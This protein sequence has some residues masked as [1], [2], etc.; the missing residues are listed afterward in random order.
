MGLWPF[1][2]QKST[3]MMELEPTLEH[4]D[5]S[6]I[7]APPST[8]A[9]E[10]L[11]RNAEQARSAQ[12]LRRRRQLEEEIASEIAE[13]GV[14]TPRV[15]IRNDVNKIA[16]RLTSS[17]KQRMGGGGGFQHENEESDTKRDLQDDE[18]NDM[19]NDIHHRTPRSRSSSTPSPSFFTDKKTSGYSTPVK[20]F[21]HYPIVSSA[22]RLHQ[23][24]TTPSSVRRRRTEEK[25]RREDS[26]VRMNELRRNIC[27]EANVDEKQASSS[28]SS[29][30]S[31][32]TSPSLIVSA[33]EQSLHS[34]SGRLDRGRR[35]SVVMKGAARECDLEN[36][37]DAKEEEGEGEGEGENGEKKEGNH[38]RETSNEPRRS[39]FTVTGQ[40][41]D[42]S[43][44][45]RR[46]SAATPPLSSKQS[47]TTTT[48]EEKEAGVEN[49]ASS[50]WSPS[51]LRIYGVVVAVV[52]AAG[53][54]V[55]MVSRRSLQSGVE[56]S[57]SAL[58]GGRSDLLVEKITSSSSMSP[59]V[60]II[61]MFAT[62]AWLYAA[63]RVLK[64]RSDE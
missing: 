48:F 51:S 20:D 27:R 22:S 37:G 21:R 31:S 9:L 15:D 62:L 7:R 44:R 53:G 42:G 49:A 25:K 10:R 32:S 54:V 64:Q 17:R 45:R 4:L 16:R 61:M 12:A 26:E 1:L 59:S 5:L 19:E 40:H 57:S 58:S 13:A 55:A 33:I 14:S 30:S 29:S 2:D 6:Q 8:P 3:T 38:H 52:L 41:V 36:D 23:I 63:W 18:E 47:T 46:E 39:A 28:S 56:E 34:M 11:R 24:P 43:A 35:K 60:L 50:S